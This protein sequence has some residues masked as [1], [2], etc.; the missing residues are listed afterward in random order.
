MEGGGGGGE[1]EREE[2]RGPTDETAV[3]ET[4]SL[5]AC[6]ASRFLFCYTIILFCRLIGI[7]VVHCWTDAN[8]SAMPGINWNPREKETLLSNFNN[9]RRMRPT[10]RITR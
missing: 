4:S 2:E 7:I 5:E 9:N 1:T 10:I 8:L 6:R 3:F